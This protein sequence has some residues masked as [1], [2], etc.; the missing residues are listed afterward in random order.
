LTRFFR[1][2][3]I[4]TCLLTGTALAMQPAFAGG[5]VAP[6]FQVGGYYGPYLESDFDTDPLLDPPPPAADIDPAEQ[7]YFMGRSTFEGVTTSERR[8]YFIYDMSSHSI[9]VGEVITSVEID[10]VLLTG[11]TSALA[12]FTGDVE[13]IEFSGTS[14]TK[15][16]ILGEAPADPLAMWDSF[17]TGPGYGGF[18]LFSPSHPTEPATVPDT[19]AI[20]LPGSF[21]DVTDAITAGDYFVLTARLATYDPDPIVPG[22]PDIYE[23]VFGGTDVVDGGVPTAL[24]PPDLSITTAPIPEPASALLFGLALPVLMRRRTR[25]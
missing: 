17:G 15:K 22:P 14:F 10:L 23:Y 4:K 6:Y 13:M 8:V 11:G 9:P 7:V 5:F 1:T 18:E 16:E 24:P 2:A 25:G 19:Y 12:N 20:S 3:V 21:A